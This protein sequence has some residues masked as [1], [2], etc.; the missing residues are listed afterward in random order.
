MT[1]GSGAL[2]TIIKS[3]SG[4]NFLP[5]VFRPGSEPSQRGLAR[6]EWMLRR[7]KQLFPNSL[8]SDPAWD[9]LVA[10]Y[11]THLAQR[12]L[13]ISNLGNITGVPATTT[14]RWVSCLV[15][16]KLAVRT[17]D[18]LDNRRVYVSLSPD[19]IALMERYC[20]ELDGTLSPLRASRTSLRT[21]SLTGLF[22]G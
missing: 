10:L 20:G 14:L 17:D 18:P 12:R 2:S 7:R 8:F 13:T 16:R 22:G 21:F 11:K 5:D 15:D 3:N 1:V 4:A 19:G 6:L 9:I